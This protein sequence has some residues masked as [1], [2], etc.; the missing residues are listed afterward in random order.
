MRVFAL[1]SC[2]TCRKA[3]KALTAA[4]KSFDVIDVRADGVAETDLKAILAQFDEK[5]MNKASA[6][7]RGLTDDEKASDSLALLKA[8]PTLM[9]RPVIEDGDQWTIGWK[10]DA[11]SVWLGE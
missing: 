6:T 9:K 2:D 8:H 11:Q 5:A 3:I 10:A 1:K 4:G 7:W